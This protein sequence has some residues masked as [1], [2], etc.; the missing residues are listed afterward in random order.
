MDFPLTYPVQRAPTLLPL[1][2]Q[3]NP[4]HTPPPATPPC[5]T[6]PFQRC[7]SEDLFS[8]AP[9]PRH[10]PPPQR[11]QERLSPSIESTDQPPP[12]TFPPEATPL[13]LQ[14][15]PRISHHPPGMLP[16]HTPPPHQSGAYASF[17]STDRSKINGYFFIMRPSSLIPLL[18]KV[19]GGPASLDELFLNP[20]EASHL[21]FC[22]WVIR[23]PLW[24]QA[25]PLGKLPDGAAMIRLLLALNL[26]RRHEARWSGPPWVEDFL[27]Y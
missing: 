10:H 14:T 17:S 8:L 25:F 3:R 1:F 6:S 20:R 21:W 19:E 23:V 4:S 22:G 27:F 24:R 13:S 9:N 7:A 5:C 18:P 15:H 11:P 26:V 12:L 16:Y 2:K